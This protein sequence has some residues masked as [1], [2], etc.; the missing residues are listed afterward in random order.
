MLLQ[1]STDGSQNWRPVA[2]AS[3]YLTETERRYA[4]IEK[5]ALAATWASE[6]FADYV[7]GRQYELETDHEPLVPL[8]SNKRLDSLPPRI[9]WFRL[10]LDKF[11]FSI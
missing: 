3:R 6:K 4:Q 9:L 2:Y 1:Q 10:R 11:D 8:L 5:E 7:L